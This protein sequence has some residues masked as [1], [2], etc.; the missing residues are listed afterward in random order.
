MHSEISAWPK[1]VKWLH[2]LWVLSITFQW[3]SELDMKAIWKYVDISAFRC[4]LLAAHM[5][6]GIASTF[7]DGAAACTADHTDFA[8]IYH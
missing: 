3:V 4:F 2:I 5:W 1:S 6:A 7:R 8:D